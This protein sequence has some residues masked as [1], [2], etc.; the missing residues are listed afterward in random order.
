M[1]AWLSYDFN[2]MRLEEVPMPRAKP[3][4]VVCKVKILELSV[5]EIAEFRGLPVPSHENIKRML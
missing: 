5:T 4:W 1:K 3:G 2:D